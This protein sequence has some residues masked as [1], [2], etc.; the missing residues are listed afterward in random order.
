VQVDWRAHLHPR[1]RPPISTNAKGSAHRTLSLGYRRSK[2]A[3]ASGQ[4]KKPAIVLETER[5]GE[6]VSSVARRHGMVTSMLFRWRADLGFS[7]NKSVKLAAVKLPDG[8]SGATSTPLVVHDLLQPPNGMTA[9]E[10]A[11]GRQ[12]AAFAHVFTSPPSESAGL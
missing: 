2:P 1:A 12:L 3:A 9:V 11:D 4:N 7:R 8:R 6:T 5:A 10:L